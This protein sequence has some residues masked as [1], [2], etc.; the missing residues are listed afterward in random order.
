MAGDY[1]PTGDAEFNTYQA[2]TVA[3]INTHLLPLGLT[4]LDPD[5]AAMNTAA[6]NWT[7][8]YAAAIAAQAAAQAANATKDTERAALTAPIRRISSRLHANSA[9]TPAQFAAA[10]FTVR[11]T[12]RSPVD[13]PTTKPVL[14]PD[15]SQRLRIIVNFAD[16][17]TPTSR[18]KPAGVMGCEIWVKLGGPPPTDLSECH[19]LA[20]DTRTPYTAEFDGSEANQTA[21][22][23]GRWVSTRS[24]PGPLSETA[25]ATI[26][27]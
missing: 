8:G 4:A 6:T 19:F 10:G 24:E 9:I 15:T 14:Q 21:H 3:Y 1:I 12:S 26:P 27:A 11:D 5:V 17:G 23:I 13:A 16:A 2:N 20:T 25:S 18:S 7:A 22:F